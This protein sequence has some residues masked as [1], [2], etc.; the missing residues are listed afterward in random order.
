MMTQIVQLMST[1]NLREN[2]RRPVPQ[3]TP[4][5]SSHIS[6]SS[7]STSGR[8]R[9]SALATMPTAQTVTL[10]AAQIP[11]FSGSDKENVELWVNKVER[12]ARIH[13][14]ADEVILLAVSGKLTKSDH[15]WFDLNTGTINETWFSFKQAIQGS[16]KRNCVNCAVSRGD[17]EGRKSQMVAQ[18]GIVS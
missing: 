16:F 15:D 7:S 2:D 9:G 18:Q 1:I 10:L 8:E 4:N 17:A 3:V 13:G 14:V 6:D 12:V 11:S 5:L